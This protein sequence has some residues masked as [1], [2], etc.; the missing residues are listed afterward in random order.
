MNDTGVNETNVVEEESNL[1]R[2]ARQELERAGWFKDDSDYGGMVGPAVMEM[3]KQFTGEGH[4]G[5]S[6]ML[7]LGL[8][9][10]VA[11][12]KLLTP[13]KNPM[14]T[15]EYIDH[16]G[17]SGGH[18]TFQ[19]TR[20]GSLFSNDGGKHWHDIDIKVPLW[21]RLLLRQNVARVKFP[22]MPD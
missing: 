1:C 22:Y 17:I 15:G 14:E 7:V 13:I 3:V 16:T 11:A 5:S 6:A 18:P 12:Y 2:H 9:R 19:S 20:L 10:R 21:R 8:F 4:S